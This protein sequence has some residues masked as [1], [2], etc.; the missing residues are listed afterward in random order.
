M[1]VLPSLVAECAFMLVFLPAVAVFSTSVGE[2][3]YIRACTHDTHM[4]GRA[5]AVA[6]VPRVIRFAA[7][8]PST[9]QTRASVPIGE[10]T[11][12]REGPM[13]AW[14][15]VQ[16]MVVVILNGV[17]D[18]VAELNRADSPPRSEQAE[19]A[20]WSQWLQ[21]RQPWIHHPLRVLR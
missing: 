5:A 10:D 14:F 15:R 4:P 3:P 8:R 18:S 9:P 6:A 16:L 2:R 21:K 20:K 17:L 13:K 12:S 7:E 11:M 19:N 1:L